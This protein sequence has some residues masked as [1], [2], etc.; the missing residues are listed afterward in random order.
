MELFTVKDVTGE[1]TANNAEEEYVAWTNTWK[2]QWL[3]L[4]SAKNQQNVV[5]QSNTDHVD[6]YKAKTC[7]EEE[8]VA[9]EESKEESQYSENAKDQQKN[10]KL[11]KTWNAN[12]SKK[13]N[14]KENTVVISEKKMEEFYPKH[15]K[16]TGNHV[17]E[18]SKEYAKQKQIQKIN[19]W[20]EH[21]A[22]TDTTTFWKNS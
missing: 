15:A 16:N 3:N 7:A 10:V 8:Y 9:L 18:S 19:V 17:L 2:E 4:N 5:Q 20:Q 11:L 6:G 1:E 21:V 22:D 13:E 14:A 12:G